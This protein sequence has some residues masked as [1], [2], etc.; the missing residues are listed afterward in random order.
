MGENIVNIFAMGAL[1]K[2][3]SEASMELLKKGIYA[4]VIIVTSPDLLL[5][6]LAHKNQY[7]YLKEELGLNAS[8]PVVSVHD[9]EPGILD[10]IGSILGQPQES[11]AVR[12]HSVCGMPSEIY[13]YHGMD[14]SSIVTA[15][16]KVLDRSAL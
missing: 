2:E 5:G 3:A 9:G 8:V 11:L 14:P 13:Q 15:V 12:R 7:V 4:N 10:N 16:L 6:S 1:G